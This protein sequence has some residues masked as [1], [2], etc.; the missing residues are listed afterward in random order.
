MSLRYR[1]IVITALYPELMYDGEKLANQIAEI[2]RAGFYNTVEFYYGGSPEKHESIRKALQDFGLH[3]VFLAGYP[4][5][6]NKWN[7]GALD[8]EKRQHALAF[9]KRLVDLSYYYGSQKMLVLSG[10][11][12]A[13][14]DDRRRSFD[15]LTESLMELCDYARAQASDYLLEITLEYFNDKGEPYLLVG[16]SSLAGQL[17]Q[18]VTEMYGHFG[19][20]FDL[21]HAIQLGED[22]L[23]SLENLSPYVRHIHLSNCVTKH[24]ENPLYGDKHPPFNIPEGDVSDEDVLMYMQQFKKMGFIEKDAI[25]GVEIIGRPPWDSR[26]LYHECTQLFARAIQQIAST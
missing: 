25:I 26:K 9:A 21:S 24:P 20:T 6:Q 3:S 17:A 14:E 10:E 7:L 13:H 15:L 2:G 11:A 8:E 12:Y 23:G 5:K 22:P 18:R 19:L 16:P 1:S 4:L